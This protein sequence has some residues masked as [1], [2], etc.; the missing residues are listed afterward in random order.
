MRAIFKKE[1]RSYFT[2]PIGYAFIAVLLA[3]SGFF[4]SFTTLW[5]SSSDTSAYFFIMILLGKIFF[6][7]ARLFPGCKSDL[8]WVLY[9]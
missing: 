2:T 1:L 5:M 7:I 4:F 6:I 8:D 3:L 9:F